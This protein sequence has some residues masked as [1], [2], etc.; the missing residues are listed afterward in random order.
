MIGILKDTQ[1]F[2]FHKIIASKKQVDLNR[3]VSGLTSPT[4]W[5][6]FAK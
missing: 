3:K 5:T 4:K 6:Y 2:I 1:F